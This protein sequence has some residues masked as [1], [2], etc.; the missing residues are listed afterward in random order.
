MISGDIDYTNLMYTDFYLDGDVLY[1]VKNDLNEIKLTEENEESALEDGI[2]FMDW[3]HVPNTSGDR[4]MSYSDK[5]S[6]V[7]I[8][9]A[10]V[11]DGKLHFTLL[12]K[13]FDK[14]DE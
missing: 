10:E 5:V 2:R 3:M 14:E 13:E 9:K 12:Y 6:N 8:Y 11:I 1:V 7:N 4:F